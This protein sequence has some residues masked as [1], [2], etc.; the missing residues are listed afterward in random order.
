MKLMIEPADTSMRSR[1][2]WTWPSTQ[3]GRADGMS[4]G[5][6]SEQAQNKHPSNSNIPS[7]TMRLLGLG[8]VRGGVLGITGEV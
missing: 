5:Q 1:A 3:A 7:S 2:I 4:G 8:M 6:R